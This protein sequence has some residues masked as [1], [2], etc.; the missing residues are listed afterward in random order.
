MGGGNSKANP[1]PCN[2][3]PAAKTR[4]CIAGF[5]MSSY[6]G[7]AH[8]LAGLVG[9]L[10]ST[11]YETWYYWDSQAAYYAFLKEKFDPIPFPPHLKGHSSSPFVWLERGDKHEIELIGGATEFQK[12]VLAQKDLASNPDIRTVAEGKWKLTDVFH[13][14]GSWPT[15]S[16]DLRK[17]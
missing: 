5:T 17:S 8:R 10:Y 7:L 1:P 12:W 2:P 11:H 14:G 16:A 4:I 9:G 6:T 3:I 13:T 15:S